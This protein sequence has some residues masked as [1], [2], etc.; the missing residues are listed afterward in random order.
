MEGEAT[1]GAAPEQTASNR[2]CIQ[3]LALCRAGL[4]S[5]TKSRAWE[6]TRR[7]TARNNSVFTDGQ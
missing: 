6:T 3:E 5:M 7:S 4:R 1:R 2:S